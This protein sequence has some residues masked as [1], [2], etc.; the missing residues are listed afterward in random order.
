M[1]LTHGFKL[2]G[3]VRMDRFSAQYADTSG[4]SYS[5]EDTLWSPRIGAIWQPSDTTSWYTSYGTSYNTSGDTYQF[6][7]GSFAAGSN[8]ART[9]NTAPEQSRN[10]EIGSKFELF[11]KKALLG[12]AFFHS[13]KFNE[14][15]TDPDSASSQM[16][17]S[18]KRHATGMEFNFAGRMTPTWEVFYN[19]TWIPDARIDVSNQA[20]GTHGTGA[21]VQGDRSALTPRH[22]ASLWTTWRLHP[23]WRIGAGLNYRGEQNPEGARHITAPAF[24]TVDAMAEVTVSDATLLKLNITNLTDKLY[25]DSLYRGFYMPGAPRRIELS[26]KTLF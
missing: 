5:R 16:L 19:H 18:G 25:A 1:S 20:L 12:V 7:L 15:N 11:E 14:R 17:L 8:N 3:G 10:L 2:V 22:S 24:T 13:E 6:A 21:Q 9:A 23:L 26:L 4:N